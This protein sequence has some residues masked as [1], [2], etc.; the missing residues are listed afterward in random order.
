MT[1]DF[2]SIILQEIHSFVYSPFQNL[3]LSD[4]V[5]TPHN[6]PLNLILNKNKNFKLNNYKL[7]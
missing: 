7:N 6:N 2:Y 5:C 1:V 4:I 3:V